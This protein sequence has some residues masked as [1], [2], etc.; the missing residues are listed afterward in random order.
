MTDLEVYVNVRGFLE[1]L[2][3]GSLLSGRVAI[4]ED[5][6][7]V[8]PGTGLSSSPRIARATARAIRDAGQTVIHCGHIPTPALAHWSI[9]EGIPGIMVTGSHIPA[10]RNGLKFYKPAGEVL[11]TDEHPIL[12][13]VAA[14]RRTEYSRTAAAAPFDAAGM[15][16]ERVASV[17][18]D[19]EAEEAYVQRYSSPF[20]G[21]APLRGTRVVVYQHSAV[22]RDSLASL[23]NGLGADV[24][25]EGRS[26]VFVAVDTEDVTE[27]DEAQF[28]SWIHEHNAD[29]L[30]STDGDSDRPLVVD[31]TG[32][33]HRGDALGIVVASYL[34][35]RVAV[36]PINSTDALDRYAQGREL[37]VSRTKIGSPYVI[38]GMNAA[39]TAGKDAVV[40]WEVN[41]GFL[42]A[43]PFELNL[44]PLTPLATRDAFLPI[45]VTLL[46]AQERGVG[47]SQLFAEFPQRATRGGLVDG[48]P[49]EI[50]RQAL[51]RFAP[52]GSAIVEE[53]F[54]ADQVWAYGPHHQAVALSRERKADALRRREWINCYCPGWG[55]VISLD[56]RDGL[57]VTF[58]SGDVAHLRASGNAPQVRVYALSSSEERVRSIVAA[59]TEERGVLSHLLEMRDP[60]QILESRVQALDSSG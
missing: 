60:T 55:E 33:F 25:C 36:V 42:T 20:A 40:G 18:F 38:A 39:L 51:A 49:S 13:A 22:G 17:E 47:V 19:P 28:R 26:E 4:A 31:E 16:R 52:A 53:R 37:S 6:R 59:V 10:D 23:L 43:S 46:S 3:S 48:I 5:L 41:G 11:K 7:K 44:C 12:A 24:I 56:H 14:A 32:R 15:L 27:E 30:V 2:R 29:V 50:T 35:A 58:A 45:I 21:Q 9:A 54:L 34:E 8:D 57:R 1:Y